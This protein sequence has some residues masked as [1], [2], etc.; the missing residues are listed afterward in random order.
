[1]FIFHAISRLLFKSKKEKS[2]EKMTKAAQNRVSIGGLNLHFVLDNSARAVS[3][4]APSDPVFPP[5][6]QLQIFA[7]PL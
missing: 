7:L 6:V 4:S 3:T 5:N 2:N 1:M